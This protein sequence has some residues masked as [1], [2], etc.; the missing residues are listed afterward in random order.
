MNNTITLPVDSTFDLQFN[1]EQSSNSKGFAESLDYCRNYIRSHAGTS[2]SYFEDYAN[3][4]VSIICVETG[5][6]V[7]VYSCHDGSLLESMIG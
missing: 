4:T 7:E 5:E 2:T 1:D 6:T 3:G